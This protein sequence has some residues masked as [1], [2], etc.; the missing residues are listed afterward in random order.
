[1]VGLRV[2]WGWPEG[3][4]FDVEGGVHSGVEG[5][6]GLRISRMPGVFLG[7]LEFFVN[8]FAEFLVGGAAFSL[9]L[10]ENPGELF[11]T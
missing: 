10:L 1:M 7:S 3:V 5:F 4:S 8:F 9:A 6:R 2:A 11:I